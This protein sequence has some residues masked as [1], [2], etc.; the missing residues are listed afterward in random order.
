M[1][2]LQ[3]GGAGSLVFYE[4]RNPKSIRSWPALEK[5]WGHL[6]K[7]VLDFYRFHNGFAHSPLMTMGLSPVE[8]MFF[9]D[10]YEW[11][12]LES[13]G[14]LPFNLNDQLAIFH[15]GMGDSICV[16]VADPNASAVI[17]FKADNP[18][19]NNGLWPVVD[20]WTVLGME[21]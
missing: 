13:L 15:N 7:S 11:G 6:P 8:G 21:T 20:A 12:I 2:G 17:W 10:E 3:T 5:V 19:L 9:L 1:Y 4:A 14:E 16:S 18:M